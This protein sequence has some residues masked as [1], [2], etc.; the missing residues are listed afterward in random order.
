MWPRF[1]TPVAFVSP[2]Y[3][4]RA[5]KTNLLCTDGWFISF[6]NLQAYSSVHSTLGTNG[7]KAFPNQI[8]KILELQQV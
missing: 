4:T 6:P 5:I 1:S 7:G 8:N 3:Q 2:S